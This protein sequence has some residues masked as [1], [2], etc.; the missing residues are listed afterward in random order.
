MATGAVDSHA[1]VTAQV[2]QAPF[3]RKVLPSR[4]ITES[5]AV[6]LAVNVDDGCTAV[7]M[8]NCRV[9]K[10]ASVPGGS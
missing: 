8:F 7:Y 10:A 3:E 5:E 2:H 6:F 1:T 9:A 4:C